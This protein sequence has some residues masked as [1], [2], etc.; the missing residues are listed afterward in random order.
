[1]NSIYLLEIVCNIT[2]FTF[3]FDQF[4]APLL[5]TSINFFEKNTLT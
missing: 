5:N 4:S 3:N 1:M 2:H